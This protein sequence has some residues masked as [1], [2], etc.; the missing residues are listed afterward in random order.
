MKDM[1]SS[2]RRIVPSGLQRPSGFW[3]S[4]SAGEASR[5]G[6]RETGNHSSNSAEAL[7]TVRKT[8]SNFGPKTRE[9]LGTQK[10]SR[11]S[12]ALFGL[13]YSLGILPLSFL[14]FRF[15]HYAFYVAAF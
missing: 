12:P 1:D 3:R 13:E 8:I 10:E 15:L 2:D 4:T 9:Q 6:P 5:L 14:R 7:L 11:P